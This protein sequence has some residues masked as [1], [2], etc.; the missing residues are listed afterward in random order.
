MI[1]DPV[2]EI[3]KYLFQTFVRRTMQNAGIDERKPWARQSKVD[4]GRVLQ[5]V[6]IL[7]EFQLTDI[8]DDIYQCASKHKHFLDRFASHWATEEI[9]KGA[10]KSRCAY[11]CSQGDADD[12]SIPALDQMENTAMNRGSQV[13]KSKK[14]GCEK[15]SKGITCDRKA[16]GRKANSLKSGDATSSK[17]LTNFS[18]EVPASE[19]SDMED[20]EGSFAASDS[21]SM[22]TV[23]PSDDDEMEYEDGPRGM[24]DEADYE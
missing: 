17:S 16:S 2:Q 4:I 23:P 8:V 9:M 5:C 18:E 1:H 10:L 22:C 14:A 7:I 13:S 21:V 24:R 3:T 20:V 11:L 15:E 19:Y 12:E 6:C